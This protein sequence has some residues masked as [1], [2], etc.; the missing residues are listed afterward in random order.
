MCWAVGGWEEGGVE[1]GEGGLQ[2]S[3]LQ[4]AGGCAHPDLGS[5]LSGREHQPAD[6]VSPC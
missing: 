5:R 2:L 3:E 1:E 4:P 6:A